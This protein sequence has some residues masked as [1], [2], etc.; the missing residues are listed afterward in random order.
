M[1]LQINKET[2][3]VIKLNLFKNMEL[4]TPLSVD[5]HVYNNCRFSEV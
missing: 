5:H 4:G 3:Y 1:I 2:S